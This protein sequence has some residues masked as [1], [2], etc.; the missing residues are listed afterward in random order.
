MTKRVFAASYQ[1]S[2]DLTDAG[3]PLDYPVRRTAFYAEQL[4]GYAESRIYSLGS[5]QT[6]YVIGVRLRTDASAGTIITD[7]GIVLPW[8]DHLVSWDYTPEDTI[9][10][11]YWPAYESIVDSRLM[12]VL[13]EG[14]LLGRGRPIDGLLC[15]YSPQPIPE[16]S[17]DWVSARLTL[18]NDVGETVA[19]GIRLADFSAPAKRSNALPGRAAKLSKG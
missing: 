18:V 5:G 9:P 17:G 3:C 4:A 2:I 12:A 11:A 14:H 15:G 7:W 1:R 6:S 16:S 8:S 13:N 19:L 10:K